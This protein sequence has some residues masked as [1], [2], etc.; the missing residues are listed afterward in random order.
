[1]TASKFA[2]ATSTF[3]NRVDS[4]RLR[5]AES[6]QVADDLTWTARK[7]HEAT[8]KFIAVR[9]NDDRPITA[10]LAAIRAV[11]LASDLQPPIPKVY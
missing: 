2:N 11:W 1:V 3:V 5:H 4:Q 7:E 6:D 9:A 10:A 8:G